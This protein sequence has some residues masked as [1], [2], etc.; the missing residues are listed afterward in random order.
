MESDLL[1]LRSQLESASRTES[2]VLLDRIRE[3][4]RKLNSYT[5]Q[6]GSFDERA[7]RYT[8]LIGRL[9]EK[10]FK[11]S[12]KTTILGKDA[13]KSEYWHFKD[14]CTRLY[15]R[16]ERQVPIKGAADA[17]AEMDDQSS[18]LE[19]VAEDLAVQKESTKVDSSE[20]AVMNSGEPA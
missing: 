20:K 12:I 2:K 17:D 6:F 14:D 4:E 11:S 10:A 16:M 19:P 13:A 15:V 1:E 8:T 18:R 9:N 7:K 3:V 5:K